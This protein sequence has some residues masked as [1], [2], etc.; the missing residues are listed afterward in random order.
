MGTAA[1]AASVQ[2]GMSITRSEAAALTHGLRSGLNMIAE[3]R[4]EAREAGLELP[5]DIREQV[6]SLRRTLHDAGLPW[7]TI[8]ATPGLEPCEN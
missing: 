5:E 7:E 6:L 3:G 2:L 4:R 8:D 1:T